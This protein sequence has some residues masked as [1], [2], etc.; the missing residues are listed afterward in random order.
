[1]S[2]LE[3]FLRLLRGAPVVVLRRY[4]RHISTA[5]G[6]ESVRK[7]HFGSDTGPRGVL[8]LR[9]AVTPPVHNFCDS[10]R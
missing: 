5:T 4:G 6:L 9:S 2:R 1:M 8:Q 3:S 10:Y 7:S